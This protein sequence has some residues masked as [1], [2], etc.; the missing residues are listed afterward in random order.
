VAWLAAGAT[1]DPLTIAGSE[2][3]A[4]A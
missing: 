4:A 3:A 1:L 2:A